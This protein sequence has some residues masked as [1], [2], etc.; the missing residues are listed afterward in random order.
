MRH[1]S[2]EDEQCPTH[3]DECRHQHFDQQAAGDDA[4]SDI[5]GG[6]PDDITVHRLYAQTDKHKAAESSGGNVWLLTYS[7]L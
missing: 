3:D 5:T 2:P 6:L 1:L 7:N 4:V